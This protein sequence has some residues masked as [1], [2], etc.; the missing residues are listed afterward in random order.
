MNKHIYDI[1]TLD[2]L[3]EY[4]MDA[5]FEALGEI[6]LVRD[7]VLHTCITIDF[8]CHPTSEYIPVD[9]RKE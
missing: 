7:N 8:H 5:G 1:E 3:V 4:L 6:R 2:E 9:S